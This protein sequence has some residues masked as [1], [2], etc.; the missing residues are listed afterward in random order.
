MGWKKDELQQQNAWVSQATQTK[1]SEG[2]LKYSSMPSA[3]QQGIGLQIGWHSQ[4]KQSQYVLGFKVV[5]CLIARM[6]GWTKA[7]ETLCLT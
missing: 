7:A 5:S 1:G 6:H 2:D 3:D 4:R